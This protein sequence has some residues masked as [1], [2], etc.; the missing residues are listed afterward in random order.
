MA[1]YVLTRNASG[2]GHNWQ[3]IS[4]IIPTTSGWSFDGDS[5][6]AEKYIGTNDNFDF[7]IRTNNIERLRVSKTGNITIG[8]S[9]PPTGIAVSI[10]SA[11]NGLYIAQSNLGGYGINI[12]SQGTGV[13][14]VTVQNGVDISSYA[15]AGLLTQTGALSNHSINPTVKILR[16]FNLNS[17]TATYPVL[18]VQ[19]TSSSTGDLLSVGTG[20]TQYFQITYNGKVKIADGTQGLNKVFT[21]DASGV[22]SW[23]S[24]SA[25]SGWN[26]VGNF[27]TIDGTNFLGTTD[28]VPLSFRVNNLKSGRLDGTLFNSFF[29]VES[30]ATN[31]GNS[32]AGFGYRAGYNNFGGSGNTLIGAYAGTNLTN[33]KTTAVGQSAYQA[34]TAVSGGIAIGY[35]AGWLEDTG[36]KFYI[37]SYESTTR[38]DGR[39]NAFMYGDMDVATPA[40]KYLYLNSRVGINNYGIASTAQLYINA[41]SGRAGI[42]IATVNTVALSIL[43][44]GGGI[45]VI[46]NAAGTYAANF[47]SSGTGLICYAGQTALDVSSY[48]NV[49]TIAQVGIL[50]ANNTSPLLSIERN[51]LIG[52]FNATGP[53]VQVVDNTLATGDILKISKMG[54]TYLR[55]I[56]TGLI[57]IQNGITTPTSYIHFGAGIAAANGSVMKFTAGV[58]SQTTK[59]VGALN[60]NGVNF[61]LTD[62]TYAYTIIKGLSN[63]AVLNFPNTDTQLFSDMTITVTGAIVGE[64]VLLG[65]D[66]AAVMPNTCYTAWVSAANT[67]TIRFNNYSVLASDP[68]SGT[69]KVT[70]VKR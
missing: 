33:N 26:T 2:I 34:A 43:S 59:E 62:A 47:Y 69:F 49:A 65:V 13:I 35:K 44:A 56:S 61:Y 1:T 29:G 60:F 8:T 23:V 54:T 17:F 21:S 5:N 22:G 3:P 41:A 39:A 20:T 11:G 25:F 10:T 67:V 51:Y 70:V 48:N 38:E 53:M 12:Q 28:N 64:E 37:S 55:Q 40:N 15:S 58:I 50:T 19:D 9:S 4:S 24:P 57:S 42:E 6:G 30:F 52:A 31:V 16:A 7:P 46:N 45:S 36:Y 68:A 32:N 18:H 66:N 63:Q 27:G 14:A